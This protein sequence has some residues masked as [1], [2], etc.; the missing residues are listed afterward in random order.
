MQWAKAMR[1]L[2]HLET[3]I[4][5]LGKVPTNAHLAIAALTGYLNLRFSGKWERGRP[6]LKAFSKKFETAF[7]ELAT[8]RPSA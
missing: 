3:R 4:P 5:R 8:L 1:G 6:K 7:P 2:D